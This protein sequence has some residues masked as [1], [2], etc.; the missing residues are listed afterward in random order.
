MH[1]NPPI[2]VDRIDGMAQLFSHHSEGC[3]LRIVRSRPANWVIAALVIFQLA[4]GLQWDV[5]QA[6]VAPPERQMNGMEAGHC[7][8]QPSKD[9]RT[10][11]GG[12]AGAPTSALS[13]HKNPV[14]KHDCCRS[15]GCQCHCAQS[16]CALDL[17][18]ASVALS[19]SILLPV[20]DVRPPV[21]RTNELFRPPI[22]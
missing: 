20:F 9:S 2:G 7:P 19:A 17:P 8:A 12:D 6:V 18:L 5:A 22:L 16:P 13:S 4:I 21:A 3:T 1:G 11:K 14:N 10:A 15:L